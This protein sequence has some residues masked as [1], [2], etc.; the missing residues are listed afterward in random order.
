MAIGF[1]VP[2]KCTLKSGTLTIGMS[3]ADDM[4]TVR[5]MTH[6]MVFYSNESGPFLP[7]KIIELGRFCV[8]RAPLTQVDHAVLDPLQKASGATTIGQQ[9]SIGSD[10]VLSPITIQSTITGAQ[11]MTFP[12]CYINE[13][14]EIAGFGNTVKKYMLEFMAIPDPTLLANASNPFYTVTVNA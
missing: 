10:V 11:S 12:K 3:D 7:A 2:G 14:I 8:V 13:P 6:P 4:I 1:E 5:E 9:G